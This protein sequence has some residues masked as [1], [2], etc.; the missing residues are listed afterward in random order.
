MATQRTA[1]VYITNSTDGNASIQLFHQN[2]SN[3]M[4]SGMWTAAPGATV[5]PLTVN[6]ETGFGSWGIL[7]YWSC[8][9]RVIDGSAPGMY[10]SNTGS[11]VDPTWSKECQLESGDAGKTLTFSVSD[12]TFNINLDSGACSDGM[13]RVGPGGPI[14]NVFVVML[15]NHSFD[16]MLA[17]SGIQ[18][19]TA[20][21]TADSNSYTNPSGQTTTYNVV[22]G[23]PPTMVTDPG[24]EFPDTLEQLAGVGATYPSGG[25]YPAINN[26]GFAA[27]YA[28]VSDEDLPPPP[29]ANIGDIMACFN[30]QTQLQ[31]L[32]ELATKGAV[33]DHWFSSLPGPTWPNRFFLHGAS[34]NAIDYSPS[35]TQ[36]A[37]WELP[38]EGFKYNHGSIY[39]L[40]SS[41]GAPY[42]FYADLKDLS[43]DPQK[44]SELGAI[45]QVTSLSGVTLLDVN[46]VLNL[47][48]DLQNPY[49][50]V[51]TFI[52]PNYGDVTDSTYVGGSSQH[53]MDDVVGGQALLQVVYEAVSNSPIWNT[54]LLI[55]TYDEHG[56]FYDSVAPPGG[57]AA[58]DDGSGLGTNFGFDFTQY[59]VRVPAIVVSPLIS[60]G[61][62][63]HTV[64]DHTSV[65]KT[66]ENMLGVG[67][68]TQRDGNANDLTHLTA[69]A[70]APRTDLPKKLKGPALS[71][72]ASRKPRSAEEH[73][74][75]MA[76]PLPESGNVW[77]FLHIMAK[78]EYELTGSTE[79]GKI[80]I[81]ENLKSIKTRGQ[82]REYIQRIQLRV[83]A[84]K[85]RRRAM[86]PQA[87][88]SAPR[89]M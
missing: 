33:C 54:S 15:E 8:V 47:A 38:L 23:A 19:I 22:D 88:M 69:A 20:A 46:E 76:Q 31:V 26:S 48:G 11:V 50:Y 59:G 75:L 82:A 71:M 72:K 68:L 4:Q 43:D 65:L 84:E 37:E 80:A 40:L 42:R 57:A 73:A 51:Y 52:E 55:V 35:P 34:S 39:D 30:T 83:A 78:T 87:Y 64:Y 53:P 29:A 86:T 85:A 25:P 74:A 58:P 6:F 45:P 77:G 44:G 24:H 12:T 81:L 7:D 36:I 21:T 62:V 49:P 67:S 10:V 41:A 66:L 32:Y 3:G 17:F 13:T 56:G 9:L 5:G 60:A 63:D 2:K 70:A 27:N 79:E 61:T 18:G 1:T 14:T 16:N 89:P 28:T